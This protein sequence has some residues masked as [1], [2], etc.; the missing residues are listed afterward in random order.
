MFGV[1][2]LSALL[3][4]PALP[5]FCKKLFASIGLAEVLQQTPHADKVPPPSEV[6][7]PPLLAEEVVIADTARVVIVGKTTFVVVFVLVKLCSSP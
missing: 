4:N 6:T 1:K 3:K 2:P 7:A 5:L